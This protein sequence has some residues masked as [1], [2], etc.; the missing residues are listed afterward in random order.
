MLQYTYDKMGDTITVSES[1]EANRRYCN[2]CK[3]SKGH[4]THQ[5]EDWLK[6]FKK[7]KPTIFTVRKGK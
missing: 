7:M 5:H 6:L 4:Y 1:E 2:K 3:A